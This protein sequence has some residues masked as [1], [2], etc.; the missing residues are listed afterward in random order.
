LINNKELWTKVTGKFNAYNILL[1]YSVAKILGISEELILECISSLN[2]PE[3]RFELVDKNIDKIGIVDYAH[4]PDSL[5]NVLLTINELKERDKA[6]ITVIGCGGNRDK[7]KRPIMGKIASS[8][9]DI[10][11][12]T[13]DNPRNENP[14]DIIN[15]MIK[16]VDVKNIN[17]VE[18]EINREEAIKIACLRANSKDVILV[19]GKGHEKYQ[20]NGNEKIEFD[21]KKVLIKLLKNNY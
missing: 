3:G 16:G 17:K 18:S 10:V 19:A 15:Q 21:D 2:S 12:F 11:I 13:S 5:K 1:V 9:S 20:I 7:S 14:K 4:S 8:L 6:T